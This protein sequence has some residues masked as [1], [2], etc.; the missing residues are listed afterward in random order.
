MRPLTYVTY[1][2]TISNL[3]SSFLIIRMSCEI[4]L[5]DLCV[6]WKHEKKG[7]VSNNDLGLLLENTAFAAKIT[8]YLL[9]VFDYTLA[10]HLSNVTFKV[11]SN[12]YNTFAKSPYALFVIVQVMKYL[13]VC[14]SLRYL[15]LFFY[16]CSSDCKTP[17]YLHIMQKSELYAQ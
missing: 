6:L 3:C 12:K 13:I 8:V 15:I 16:T 11:N 1:S 9:P 7:R 4:S 5:F 2:K 14:L 17:K 10:K